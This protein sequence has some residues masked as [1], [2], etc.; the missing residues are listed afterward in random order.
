M[1][2]FRVCVKENGKFVDKTGWLSMELP[3]SY[4]DK[5]KGQNYIVEYKRG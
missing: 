1:Y 3:I 4:L 2:M 5:F